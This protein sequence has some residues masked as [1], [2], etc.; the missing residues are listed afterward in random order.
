MRADAKRHGDFAC[1]DHWAAKMTCIIV[2][3]SG[4]S[5][6]SLLTGDLREMLTSRRNARGRKRA[7]CS[8]DETMGIKTRE[9]MNIISM[10]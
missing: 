10:S 2:R 1:L 6:S 5:P 9:Q 8:G 7:S 4:F 3:N